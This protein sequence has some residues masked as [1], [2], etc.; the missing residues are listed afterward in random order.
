MSV[1]AL[2]GGGA[3]RYLKTILVKF[4]RMDKRFVWFSVI[5]VIISF[6]GGF[7]LANAF[8]R[9]EMDMLRA[10]NA[11]LKNTPAQTASQPDLTPEEIKQRI[12]EADRNPGNFSFQKNLGIALY[13]YAAMKQDA[14]LLADTSRILVRANELNP[15]D[16]EILVALG[17]LFF[18]IGYFKKDNEKFVQSREFYE[19]AL[20]QRPADVEV[21]TDYGLTFFLENP[22]KNEQAIAEF[23]KSLA[24]NPKHERSLQF[25]IQAYLKTGKKAEA[26]NY[27]ARLKQ[28]NPNAP[29]LSEIETQVSQTDNILQQQ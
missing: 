18:D 29:S 5:A 7:L 1:A 2:S 11:R 13:R 20:S 25:L 19:K 12:A 27:L 14:E 17:N 28:I 8:N 21:I 6:V 23:Q 22:P 15:K 3:H 26:E 16:Y 10:E 24:E 4:Y 9:S